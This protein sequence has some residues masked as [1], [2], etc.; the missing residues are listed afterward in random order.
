MLE[1]GLGWEEPFK[2]PMPLYLNP[3][4]KDTHAYQHDQYLSNVR[5]GLR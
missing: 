2:S 4:D 5:Y 3:G 1:Q